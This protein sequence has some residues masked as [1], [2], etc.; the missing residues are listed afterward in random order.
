ML[1]VL[2]AVLTVTIVYYYH[3]PVA[4]AAEHEFDSLPDIVK[5]SIEHAKT[6]PGAGVQGTKE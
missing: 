3:G 6:L 1:S 2:M 5:K 4:Y